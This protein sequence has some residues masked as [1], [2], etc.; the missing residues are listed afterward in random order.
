M[1]HA[2]AEA[3]LREVLPTIAIPTLLLHGELDQRSPIRVARDL[4]AGIPSARLVTLP[5][6]GHLCNAEAPD[7]FNRQ[8]KE[9]LR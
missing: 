3:D 9:F 8:V 2:L 6:V 1:A 7:E 5:G 4:H